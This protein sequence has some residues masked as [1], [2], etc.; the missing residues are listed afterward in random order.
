LYVCKAREQNL[1]S[2][3]ASIECAED[4]DEGN[5]QEEFIANEHTEFTA[6][7]NEEFSDD[8]VV[9]EQASPTSNERTFPLPSKAHEDVVLIKGTVI[10]V[11]FATGLLT[12]LMSQDG[13]SSMMFCLKM[14]L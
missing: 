4:E 7:E 12:E 8:E 5:E 6:N 3:D 1:A 10:Y 13:L 14:V 9:F 2:G 11:W